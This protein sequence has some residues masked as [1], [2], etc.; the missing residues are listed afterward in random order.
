[1]KKIYF[2]LIIFILGSFPGFGNPEADEID[3]LLFLPNISD[4]F[5]DN[6][7]ASMQLDAAADYL[8]RR[9]LVDGQIFVRGY[10][11]YST[12]VTDIDPVALSKERALFVI[13]QLQRRGVPA[14]LFSE[15][16]AVGVVDTWGDNIDEETRSPNRRVRIML[17]GEYLTPA[18]ITAAANAAADA[19]PA[20]APEESPGEFLWAWLL[21]LLFVPLIV[22]ALKKKKGKAPDAP[23]AAPVM[24]TSKVSMDLHEEIRIRAYE[25]YLRR[26]D[27][28]KNHLEDWYMAVEQICSR[29]QANGYETSLS[30]G[31]W[32]AAKTISSPAV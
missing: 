12:R 17:D 27:Q 30:N 8:R 21:P 22:F 26:N 6:E 28:S 11:A 3:Y 14:Y 7:Q 18:I 29:Y 15:P 20:P 9:N 24:V 25:L 4:Q 5:V 19:A 13:N 23:A 2:L 1:M 16:V 31:R 32:Q 10:A